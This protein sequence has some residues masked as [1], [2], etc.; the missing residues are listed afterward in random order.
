LGLALADDGTLT[1][2]DAA[3]RRAR[4]D[5]AQHP[6][7]EPQ[8]GRHDLAIARGAGRVCQRA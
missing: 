7:P 1:H 4:P 5:L 8:R 3:D 6:P 2:D